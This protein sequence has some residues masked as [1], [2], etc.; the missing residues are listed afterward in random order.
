MGRN[1]NIIAKRSSSQEV[2]G[3]GGVILAECP[4]PSKVKGECG[5]KF[6]YKA[7]SDNKPLETSQ[8]HYSMIM[9]VYIVQKK[10]C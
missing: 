1:T 8:K 7:L 4:P 9:W 6:N 5:Q 10:I 2:S 3:M